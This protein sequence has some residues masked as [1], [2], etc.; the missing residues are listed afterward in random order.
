ME[1]RDRRVD[2]DRVAA[3][4]LA[5]RAEADPCGREQDA[6]HVHRTRVL[7]RLVERLPQLEPAP[8]LELV[9][10][11]RSLAAADSLPRRVHVDVDVDDERVET[12][13]EAR[14]LDRAGLRATT[15]AS[16]RRQASTTNLAS[17]SRN[18]ASLRVAKSPRSACAR[19][20]SRRRRRGTACRGGAT[21]API[22]DFPRPHEADEG[23]VPV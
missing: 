3:P 18:A 17:S 12:V 4:R 23:D 19:A 6:V 1:P 15:L 10:R 22:V 2:D 14:G 13:D 7:D 16:L 20:R 11:E 21:S 8:E 9:L 5:M